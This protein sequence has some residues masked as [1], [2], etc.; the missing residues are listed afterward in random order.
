LYE[1][2]KNDLAGIMLEPAGPLGSDEIGHAPDASREFLETIATA[3]R[4]AGAMLNL[5]RNRYR[6]SLPARQRSE[7][8]RCCSR[9]DLPWQSPG[10][11]YAACRSGRPG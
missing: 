3:A 2:H 11:G 5:R 4:D 7:G 1:K 9:H 8:N 10:L 6:V